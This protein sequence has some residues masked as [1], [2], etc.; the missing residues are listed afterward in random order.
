MDRFAVNSERR[1][2]CGC[3]QTRFRA[4]PRLVS[5]GSF[6]RK[7][8][9]PGA[10]RSGPEAGL[11]V[12]LLAQTAPR[13]VVKGPLVRHVKRHAI[14]QAVEALPHLFADIVVCPAD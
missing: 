2:I 8:L 11:A 5:Q 9:S 3:R 1:G 4:R 10:R 14:E 7:L 6:A 13:G 12:E